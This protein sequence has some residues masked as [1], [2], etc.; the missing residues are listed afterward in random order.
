MQVQSPYNTFITTFIH[1]AQEFLFSY[2]SLRV[3][4]AKRWEEKEDGV[5]EKWRGEM[6]DKG[7]R[8]EERRIE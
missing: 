8:E 2:L 7:E 1:F 5:K 3:G 6:K 4:F